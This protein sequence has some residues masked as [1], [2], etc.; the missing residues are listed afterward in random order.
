[1]SGNEKMEKDS[2]VVGGDVV[3]GN[4][5]SGDMVGGDKYDIGEIKDSQAVAIGAGARAEINQ[6]TE[7][8][9]KL[10]TI[11]DLPPAP[12][13]PPYKGLA[14]FTEK[15]ADI[16]YGRESLSQHIA[17]RLAQQHFLALIGA[18]GSGKSSLLRAGI[19]PRLRGQNWLI[20]VMTP[21]VHPLSA[22]ANS[23]GRHVN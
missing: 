12:G 23:L 20:H 13:E 18:S 19:I 5:V 2:T 4:K 1:M 16:Y 17:T 7:I 14:Y 22:L 10:D 11:E 6:Y 15:D 9:V 3:Y 21:G 8:I